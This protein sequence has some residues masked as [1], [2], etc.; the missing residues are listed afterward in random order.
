MIFFDQYDNIDLVFVIFCC[1]IV[2]GNV[3]VLICDNKKLHHIKFM[4]YLFYIVFW[5]VSLILL[6]RKNFDDI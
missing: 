4:W 2:F 6:R 1:W 5:P 3:I